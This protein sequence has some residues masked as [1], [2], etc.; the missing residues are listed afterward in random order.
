MVRVL[1]LEGVGQLDDVGGQPPLAG[2]QDPPIGV[3]ESGEIEVREL[4]QRVLGLGK[5][6]L[7]RARRGA[8]RGDGRRAG[9][10]RGAA[11]IAQQRL[12][13][14]GV[15]GGAPGGEHRVGLAGT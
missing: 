15:R 5:A 2:L 8:E 3:G 7:E 11:G 10:G 6:R 1:L 9:R 13:R 4:V 12:A 14:R